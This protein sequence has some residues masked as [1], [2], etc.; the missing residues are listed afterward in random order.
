M[1]QWEVDQLCH[2]KPRFVVSPFTQGN[3]RAITFHSEATYVFSSIS[4]S[5]HPSTGHADN[6]SSESFV[7]EVILWFAVIPLVLVA[8]S[9]LARTPWS[10]QHC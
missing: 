4:P 3:T 10:F 6:N 7:Y 2:W 9:S 1:D 8:A 5:D